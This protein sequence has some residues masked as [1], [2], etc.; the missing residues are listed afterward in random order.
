MCHL[1]FWDEGRKEGRKE[2]RK[3]GKKK[4][5]EGRKVEMGGGKEE[6]RT[7]RRVTVTENLNIP[8]PLKDTQKQGG[9]WCVVYNKF[10]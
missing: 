5:E 10:L 1:F 7:G 3:E 6:R 2:R 9:P 8:K 4:G